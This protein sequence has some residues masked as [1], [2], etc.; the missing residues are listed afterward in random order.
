MGAHGRER[1]AGPGCDRGVR[2]EAVAAAV[3]LRHAQRDRH[4]QARRQSRVLGC[5]VLAPER[6]E[7]RGRVGRRGEEQGRA[8]ERLFDG[9]PQRR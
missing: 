8:A 7:R 9:S 1:D 3:E 4:A 6:L 5:L 2:R